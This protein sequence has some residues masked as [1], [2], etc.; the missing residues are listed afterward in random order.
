MGYTVPMSRKRWWLW[1]SLFIIGVLI[2][3][4]LATGWNI[5]LVKE[6]RLIGEQTR[7]LKFP[8]FGTPQA[9]PWFELIVGMAGFLA[10][11]AALILFFVRLLQEMRLNQLQT[12]FLASVTHALKTPI[13]TVEL[14]G[15][16]LRTDDLSQ[17]ERKKLWKSFDQEL[18]RLKQ[19]VETLLEASRWQGSPKNLHW[20]QIHLQTWLEKT[21]ERWQQILPEPHRVTLEGT[22]LDFVVASDP[23]ILRLVLD[24]LIE[25]ARKFCN[26]KAEIRVKTEV[27]ETGW[28]ILVIDSGWGFDP[29]DSKKIFQ[30]FWRSRT[31][32]PHTVPGTGLGLHLARNASRAIALKLTGTSAGHGKGACFT[33]EGGRFTP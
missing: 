12:E 26:V 15:S 22:P 24:N 10:T 32:A 14:S 33:L 16:L 20:K 8:R 13:A 18:K 17:D 21:I 25:N 1:I 4:G 7:S 29:K 30:R 2:I 9:L 28:R 27:D 19:E 5:V 11:L 3:G 23:E 31:S 6:Y